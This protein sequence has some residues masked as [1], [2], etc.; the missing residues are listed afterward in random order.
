MQ[1]YGA[2]LHQHC[3]KCLDAQAVQRW[4]TVQQYR[5]IFDHLFEYV[6]YLWLH[7]LYEAFGALDVVREVLL[8]QFAHHKR[9]KEFQGHLLG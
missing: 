1:L 6:P 8:Y 4:R 9:L 7:A 3:L 5:V 2:A